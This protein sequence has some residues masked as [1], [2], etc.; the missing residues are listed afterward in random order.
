MCIRDRGI[1][2]D[3]KRDLEITDTTITEEDGSGVDRGDFIDEIGSDVPFA[4]K[5][6]V[7]GVT[8]GFEKPDPISIKADKATITGGGVYS[9]NQVPEEKVTRQSQASKIELNAGSI[10][11]SQGTLE[12]VTKLDDI[13]YVEE[14]VMKR[15]GNRVKV[16]QPPFETVGSVEVYLNGE[17]LFEGVD[18]SLRFNSKGKLMPVSFTSPLP[19]GAKV[20]FIIRAKNVSSP[21]VVS[22]NTL[23]GVGF[24]N[25]SHIKAGVVEMDVGPVLLYA[26]HVEGEIAI[27]I[28]SLSLI[29]I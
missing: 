7:L 20:E 22:L 9:V 16:N 18:Y 17:R 24:M 11:M 3:L 15:S 8:E 27:G 6:G 28:Q 10:Q 29:H 25:G 19:K 2:I 12:G 14:V 21:P 13:K 23:G 4:S 1:T 26:S 5:V